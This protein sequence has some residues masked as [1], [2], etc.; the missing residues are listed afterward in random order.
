MDSKRQNMWTRK[1]KPDKMIIVMFSLSFQSES[2][3]CSFLLLHSRSRSLPTNCS[4]HEPRDDT[5]EGSLI[6]SLP[7]SLSF[8][9][10][11]YLF[12]ICLYILEFYG[13]LFDICLF[14]LEIHGFCSI[15]VYLFLKFVDLDISI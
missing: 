4:S 6:F 5:S 15:F 3:C 9:R 13:F 8:S 1:R 2:I 14:V 10:I 11:I 12:D 7:L